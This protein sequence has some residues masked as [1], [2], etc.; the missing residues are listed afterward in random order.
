MPFLIHTPFPPW[1]PG[2]KQILLDKNCSWAA[3]DNICLDIY[4]SVEL[5][6][7]LLSKPIPRYLKHL[8]YL[9]FRSTFILH[10]ITKC[11]SH[12]SCVFIVSWYN[13]HREKSIVFWGSCTILPIILYDTKSRL[14]LF[15]CLFF[16]TLIIFQSS[17]TIFIWFKHNHL[18]NL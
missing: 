9:F 17:T 13:Y 11:P 8:K 7:N 14:G 1:F 6:N 16:C 3:R 15:H 5:F 12:L 4:S 10:K 18:W 2:K